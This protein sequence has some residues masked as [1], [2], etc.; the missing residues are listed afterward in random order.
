M[1]TLIKIPICIGLAGALCMPATAS[2]AQEGGLTISATRASA[3]REC[4]TSAAKYPDYA[5]G[6]F[7]MFIYRACMASDAQRE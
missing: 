4:A 7:E 3:I 6:N 1:A 5:W 2:G